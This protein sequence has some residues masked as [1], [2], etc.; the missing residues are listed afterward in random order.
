MKKASQRL[1]AV[2]KLAQLK[3]KLAAEKLAATIRA[4]DSQKQQKQQLQSFQQE[5]QQ[6][7][8]VVGAKGASALQLMNYQKFYGS[9]QNAVDVQQQRV[10]LS[11]SQCEQARSQWQRLYAEQKN[12]EKLVE[13]KAV[14]ETLE[15]DKKIQR[16]QDDRQ[17]RKESY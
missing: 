1:Q 12:M 10:N 6:Q 17:P 5:Y 15:A 13:R 14:E 8:Q 2:L 3:E 9:L 16:E 4:T 7:F 11:D